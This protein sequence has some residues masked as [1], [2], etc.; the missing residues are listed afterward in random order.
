MILFSLNFFYAVPSFE[1][2]DSEV[3][4]YKTCEEFVCSYD[5]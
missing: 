1:C 3:S 4:D 2:K 5:D